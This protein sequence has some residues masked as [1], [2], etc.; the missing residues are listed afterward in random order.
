MYR[1]IFARLLGVRGI[2]I[3]GIE[4]RVKLRH[5]FKV[6]KRERLAAVLCAAL[7]LLAILRV[8]YLRKFID[9]ALHGF[10]KIEAGVRERQRIRFLHVRELCLNLR[11]GRNR[12]FPTAGEFSTYEILGFQEIMQFLNED[13]PELSVAAEG[14][15]QEFALF[16]RR[17][18]PER[19]VADTG[20]WALLK[21]AEREEFLVE[22][23]V[24]VFPSVDNVQFFW[25]QIHGNPPP[26]FGC[27][28]VRLT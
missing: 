18:S 3:L 12:L 17:V 6:T 25:L 8:L 15:V 4:L 9:I 7:R 5:S 19:P 23:G 27:D 14:S 20:D 10:H 13:I 1:K 11:G 16:F 2:R 24:H 28:L 26:F 21:N 22:F